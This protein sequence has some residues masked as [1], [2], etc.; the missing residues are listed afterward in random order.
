MLELIQGDIFQSGAEA[1]VDPVNCV[2]VSGAG[3]AIAVPALGCGLG[4][5]DW[6]Q[7]RGVIERTLLDLD[8]RAMLYEP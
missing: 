2:G 1:L 4:G 8:T 5:L 6:D 3:L 7:V